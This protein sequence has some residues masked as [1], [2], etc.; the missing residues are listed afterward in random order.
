MEIDERELEVA[1]RK[2]ITIKLPRAIQIA[3]AVTLLL[4]I[5]TSEKRKIVSAVALA[6]WFILLV[7]TFSYRHRIDM[8]LYVHGY[9][10]EPE[11]FRLER[12]RVRII[13]IRSDLEK[14]NE[15]RYDS[16]FAEEKTVDECIICLEEEECV[17]LKCKHKFGKKCIL[18]W[19]RE[20][21]TCPL[22]RAKIRI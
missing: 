18:T 7:L 21:D 15:S 4:I 17:E 2:C 13:R 10:D 19:L 11:Y 20:N 5:N 16:L 14:E 9:Q 22:C 1:P 6:L 8:W 12:I 3:L